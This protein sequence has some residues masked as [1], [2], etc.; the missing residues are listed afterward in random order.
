M[1]Y[2]FVHALVLTSFESSLTNLE[3]EVVV[4]QDYPI[5]A[6]YCQETKSLVFHSDNQKNNC[7]EK[8]S[9]IYNL[10]EK[11][12]IQ[13]SHE[14]QILILSDDENEYSEQDVLKYFSH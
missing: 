14:Q 12:A 6:L 11:L 4:A 13:F 9:E 8:I 3:W 5:H 7:A 2:H 10:L 1:K